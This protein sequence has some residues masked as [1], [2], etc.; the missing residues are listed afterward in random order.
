MLPAY[1][2]FVCEFVF[3]KCP[4]IFGA[5]VV[6]LP[7]LERSLADADVF[8][9]RFLRHFRGLPHFFNGHCLPR[10]LRGLAAP[11]GFWLFL[12]YLF[13]VD[14]VFS[15]VVVVVCPDT[16]EHFPEIFRF[17]FG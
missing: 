2:F 11:L 12:C 7:P 16:V 3:D 15:V 10:F 9:E 4:D 17:S 8:S 5:G 1:Y 13:D 6:M 14:V